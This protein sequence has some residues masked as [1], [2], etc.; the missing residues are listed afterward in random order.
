[1]KNCIPSRY[2]GPRVWRLDSELFA[3]FR[4]QMYS[5]MKLWIMYLS[6]L[7]PLLKRVSL[8]AEAGEISKRIVDKPSA[9][10]SSDGLK[11][12][13]AYHLRAVSR[14]MYD[15]ARC[16]SKNGFAFRVFIAEVFICSHFE[17]FFLTNLLNR[18]FRKLV[19][20]RQPQTLLLKARWTN[21]ISSTI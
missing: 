4:P 3:K 14:M 17:S 6:P 7:Q 5:Y 12:W 15:I 19:E 13:F 16:H 21:W 10:L 1:M 9:R 2:I 8:P 11:R 20:V 18:S